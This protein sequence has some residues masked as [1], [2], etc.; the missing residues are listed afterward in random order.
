MKRIWNY[1]TR[2]GIDGQTPPAEIRYIIFSNAIVV[3]VI[4]LITQN[5]VVNLAYHVDK[6]LIYVVIA[7][8]IFIGT[9]LVWNKLKL[10]L[11]ARVWFGVTAAIFLTTY[12]ALIGTD[13]R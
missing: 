11:L 5:L 8:G 9:G 3:L 2:T 7:H 13:S 10:F 6:I 4:I 12:Q 1:L